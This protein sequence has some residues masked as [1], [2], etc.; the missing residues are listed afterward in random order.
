MNNSS[1]PQS[2]SRSQISV[3]DQFRVEIAKADA[4]GALRE[5][6]TLH[7]TPSDGSRL[8]RDPTVEI[9]DI[10]FKD[11]VM[12]FLGVKVVQG[13]VTRSLLARNDAE[14]NELA[15][16]PEVTP[17]KKP[18]VKKAAV[19]KA[20]EPEAATPVKKP[21]VKKAAKAAA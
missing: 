4:D 10:S 17:V 19:K 8:K 12:R 16:A 3:A 21:A 18:A 5:E 9:S 7:L 15:P 20:P 14:S 2:T 13:R 11:G 1:S 6:M